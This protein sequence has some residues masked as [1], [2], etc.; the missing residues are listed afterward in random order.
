MS[1]CRICGAEQTFTRSGV[2][3]RDTH[4]CRP[5]GC[6][7]ATPS[8]ILADGTPCPDPRHTAARSARSAHQKEGGSDLSA[9]TLTQGGS[10]NRSDRA[11]EPPTP[12]IST[13]PTAPRT[14]PRRNGRNGYRPVTTPTDANAWLDDYFDTVL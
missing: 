14:A 7:I 1:A 4:D 9:H 5:P 2:T 6:P 11:V 3:N 8:H 10:K 12:V 13:K